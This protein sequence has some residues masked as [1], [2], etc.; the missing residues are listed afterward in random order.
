[1]EDTWVCE[2]F[3]EFIFRSLGRIRSWQYDKGS[4]RFFHC[5][6]NSCIG[7]LTSTTRYKPRIKIQLSSSSPDLIKRGPA[8]T[9][10]LSHK[11]VLNILIIK[12]KTPDFFRLKGLP[13]T[14]SRIKSSNFCKHRSVDLAQKF[15]QDNFRSYRISILRNIISICFQRSQR[16]Y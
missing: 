8:F 13:G 4:I 9:K 1:M 10:F 7:I 2:K 12:P 6:L 5:T 15:R 3:L 16:Q 14:R 11:V